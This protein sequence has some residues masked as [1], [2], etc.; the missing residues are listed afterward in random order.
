MPLEPASILHELSALFPEFASYWN[1]GDN[2][3]LEDDGSFSYHGLFAHFSHF[4]REQYVGLAPAQVQALAAK[5]NCWFGGAVPA[6]S[7]AVATCFLE[8]IAGEACASAVKPLLTSDA[9][10]YLARWESST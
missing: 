5:V 3:F 8:N 1:H 10:A 9:V 4:F 2:Y 7:N 6:L